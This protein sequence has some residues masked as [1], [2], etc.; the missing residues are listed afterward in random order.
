MVVSEEDWFVLYF[1]E[2]FFFCEFPPLLV[3]TLA[4]LPSKAHDRPLVPNIYLYSLE[5]LFSSNENR[6]FYS[7][8][9]SKY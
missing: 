1:L 6:F 5:W 3:A 7:T 2:L 8:L 9:N 4:S